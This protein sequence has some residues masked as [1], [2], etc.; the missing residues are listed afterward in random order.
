MIPDIN[1][2]GVLRIPEGIE[3]VHE[4]EFEGIDELR[5]LI[6]PEQISISIRMI[7]TRII[8]VQTEATTIPVRLS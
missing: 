8:R 2:N 7:W 4:R 1:S 6:L 3:T 5:S